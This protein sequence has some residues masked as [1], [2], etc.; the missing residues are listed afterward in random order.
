[1]KDVD[2][3]KVKYYVKKVSELSEHEMAECADLFSRNYGY[4]RNDAPF[5][6]GARIKMSTTFFSDRYMHDDVNIAMARN[7]K[8]LIGQAIYIRKHYASI[9]TMT[10]VLQLVVADHYRR[11]GIGS[12]LLYSIWGMS[13]DF[14]WGLA[15]ANPCTVK[16]LEGATFRKCDSAVIHK[17]IKYI[18]QLAKETGF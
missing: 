18:K 10:W 1:M 12:T 3:S 17:N 15:T 13:N 5:R 16:A 7:G 4:Y 11:F 8:Y 6:P 9:G 2:T 14:A